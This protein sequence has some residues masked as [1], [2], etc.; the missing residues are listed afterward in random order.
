MWRNVG[1]IISAFRKFNRRPGAILAKNL[2]LLIFKWKYWV[3][4]LFFVLDYQT[5]CDN[6]L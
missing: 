1:K 2:V 3:S 5:V 4:Y 6:E